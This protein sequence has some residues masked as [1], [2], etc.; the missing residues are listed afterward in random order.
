[1]AMK[2]DRLWMRIMKRR[3]KL[4]KSFYPCVFPCTG[5]GLTFWQTVRWQH[6]TADGFYRRTKETL[7]LVRSG[8]VS[9]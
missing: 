3:R 9:Q 6:R 5:R 2:S 1:M 4:I 8:L 7:S